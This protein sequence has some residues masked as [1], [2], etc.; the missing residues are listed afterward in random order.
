MTTG[1]T[2]AG[3]AVG[4][5][6]AWAN[7]RPWWK[8]GRAP[9]DLLPFTEGF[10]LGAMSTVCA[11]L[12]GWAASGLAGGATTGGDKVTV[13]LTGADGGTPIPRGSMGT[14]TSEGAV[15]VVLLTAGVALAW[16]VAPKQDKRRIFGG[17]FVGVVLC[18]TAGIASAL[19]WLPETF[20]IAGD[21]VR[22]AVS[23]VDIL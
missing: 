10:V 4:L 20:N 23:G 15:M 22:N 14:L 7:F 13:G 3:L 6:V 16:K 2:L 12:L 17:V 8:G 18:A 1:I 9:K 21:Y 19:D 5:L 11:G